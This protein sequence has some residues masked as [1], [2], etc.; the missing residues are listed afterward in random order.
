MF[1]Y[2]EKPEHLVGRRLL[3]VKGGAHIQSE[4]IAKQHIGMY[5]VHQS[6]FLALFVP[7]P[8]QIAD[9]PEHVRERFPEV[10]KPQL[11]LDELLR[12]IVYGN[13]PPRVREGEAVHGLEVF[14]P[15]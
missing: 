14:D 15:G 8:G 4:E 6:A 3:V 5:C 9:S 2:E 7:V 13:L 1:Q 11:V 10:R 12:G